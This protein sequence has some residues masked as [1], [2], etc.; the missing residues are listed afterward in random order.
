M[1]NKYV[2]VVCTEVYKTY[3]V[4]AVDPREAKDIALLGQVDPE[5]D[6]TVVASSEVIS[7]NGI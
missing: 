7:C 4:E 1:K 2:V 6:E 3:I 5:E